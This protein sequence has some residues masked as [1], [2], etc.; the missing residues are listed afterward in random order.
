MSIKPILYTE[1]LSFSVCFCRKAYFQPYI[2][3]AF[4]G[5]LYLRIGAHPGA[6]QPYLASPPPPTTIMRPLPCGV[7]DMVSYLNN[8]LHGGNHG[9]HL[10]Q[11]T[12]N[13]AYNTFYFSSASGRSCDCKYCRVSESAAIWPSRADSARCSALLTFAAR[14]ATRRIISWSS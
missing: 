12:R 9:T 3:S 8:F 13:P 1:F 11:H 10:C 4:C 7:C 5:T 6:A 2:S 14:A